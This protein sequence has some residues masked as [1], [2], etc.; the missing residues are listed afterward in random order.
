MKKLSVKER[1][2][3]WSEV[4]AILEPKVALLDLKVNGKPKRRNKP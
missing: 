3:M 2:H 4:A 1:T